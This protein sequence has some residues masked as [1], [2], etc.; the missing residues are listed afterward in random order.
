MT[1]NAR[2]GDGG[3]ADIERGH[4]RSTMAIATLA[5]ILLASPA[6]AYDSADSIRCGGNLVKVG[7]SLE[8]LVESCG[9]PLRREGNLWYYQETSGSFVK[10]VGVGDGEV[11]FI[12]IEEK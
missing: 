10:A 3:S 9:E 12:R 6:A 2:S 7:D 11:L 5:V 4:S 1:G 8:H